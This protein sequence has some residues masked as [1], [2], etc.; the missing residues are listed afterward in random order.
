MSLYFLLSNNTFYGLVDFYSLNL[1]L[2]KDHILYDFKH[3]VYGLIRF[4]GLTI[5]GFLE[6]YLKLLGNGKEVNHEY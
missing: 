6:C 4:I 2:S 1:L 5:K 3:N